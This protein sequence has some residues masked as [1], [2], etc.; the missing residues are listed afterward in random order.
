MSTKGFLII[1]VVANLAFVGTVGYLVKKQEAAPVSADLN[2]LVTTQEVAKIP[3]P[4]KRNPDLVQTNVAIPQINWRMV[5]SEDYRQYIVNLRS[6]GCPEE[7][8]RD[9][10]TAD[11]NKLF[12]ARRKEMRAAATNKFEFWKA[13]NMFAGVMDEEKIKQKQELAKEKK[14]LLTTLLGAAPEEKADLG[15]VMNP[16]QDLLDFLPEGKQAKVVDLMQSMQAK[17]MKSMKDGSPDAADLKEMQKVQK[18]MEAEI[19]KVL[20]PQEFEDYQ[21]RLSQTS[22]MMRMQLASFDPSEQEFRE[23]FKLQKKFDDD[24][25]TM[26]MGLSDDPEKL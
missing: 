21:L 20:T 18:D 13:G 11:V 15:A 26:G 9:I 10:I 17:A 24:Y 22:M 3:A 5:E 12:E 16:F 25:G 1:S 8:I 4:L 2:T 19:A 7:T 6:I 14:E 23:I